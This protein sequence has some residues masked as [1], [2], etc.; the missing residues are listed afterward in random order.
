M[1]ARKQIRDFFQV[2]ISSRRLRPTHSSIDCGP[3][4]GSHLCSATT[5]RVQRVLTLDGHWMLR[6]RSETASFF[7]IHSFSDLRTP[8]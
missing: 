3:H 5:V 6:I 7:P 2:Q 4:S 8:A 1:G